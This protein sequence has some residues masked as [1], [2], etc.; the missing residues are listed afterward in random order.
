MTTRQDR[1]CLVSYIVKRMWKKFHYFTSIYANRQTGSG[2]SCFKHCKTN[3]EKIPLL[4]F[5][6]RKST[7]APATET[8]DSSS[9]F[10]PVKSNKENS[11]PQFSCLT[12]N[13]FKEYEVFES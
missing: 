6:L 11:D 8:L 10:T 9:F 2:V 4:H 13:H 1:E 12:F 7:R 5:H 3:V